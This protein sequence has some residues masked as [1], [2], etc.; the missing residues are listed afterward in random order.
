[1]MTS[2]SVSAMEGLGLGISSFQCP[3]LGIDVLKL[4]FVLKGDA[5]VKGHQSLHGSEILVHL[6]KTR[7]CLGAKLHEL[8]P[9]VRIVLLNGLED[10]QNDVVW[11]RHGT[12]SPFHTRFN[13]G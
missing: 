4:I 12:D 6:I 3:D 11:L 8:L 5:H 2:N 13:L 10:P 9:E 7:I 1:M